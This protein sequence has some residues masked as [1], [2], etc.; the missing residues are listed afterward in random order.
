ML[1]ILFDIQT[2]MKTLDG[3]N[4]KIHK[5]PRRYLEGWDFHDVA[6]GADPIW[7][8]QTSLNEWGW[9]WV[10][11]VRHINA[12]VLFGNG[13]GDII[14][15]GRPPGRPTTSAAEGSTEAATVDQQ[16]EEEHLDPEEASS[17]LHTPSQSASPKPDTEPPMEFTLCP[18]CATLPKKKTLLATTT[19]VLNGIIENTSQEKTRPHQVQLY[20]NGYWHKPA[21]LFEAC[22][23]PGEAAAVRPRA[24]PIAQ[25]PFLQLMRPEIAF[26]CPWRGHIRTQPQVPSEVVGEARGVTCA[27]LGQY[28]TKLSPAP[29]AYPDY[30]D[31]GLPYLPGYSNAVG[32]IVT[33]ILIL[34]LPE[35]GIVRIGRFRA[36]ADRPVP[37]RL[38]QPKRT[39]DFISAEATART[40]DR[41]DGSIG[42]IGSIGRSIGSRTTLSPSPGPTYYYGA[43]RLSTTKRS[44]LRTVFDGSLVQ[45]RSGQAVTVVMTHDTQ[46][47]Q[48]VATAIRGFFKPLAYALILL[49]A[50]GYPSVFCGDLYGIKGDD[51]ASDPPPPA[52]DYWDDANC[53]GFVRRGTAH[54]PAGLV[55]VMSNAGSGQIKMNI[56]DIHRGGGMERCATVAEDEVIIDDKGFGMFLCVAM[57]VSIWVRKDAAGRERFG[58]L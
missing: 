19:A 21:L 49:R 23:C 41:T 10:D 13:F 53:I 58:K 5:S 25:P 36:S 27:I 40:T 31:V 39:T 34:L 32:N 45:A 8:R 11:L 28:A 48:T 6:T 42:S 35:M 14:Q 54:H 37:Y 2:D 55:C 30:L 29:N 47:G 20:P 17:N 12:I 33:D 26:A 46:P 9:G 16:T 7:P 43:S 1:G 57:S 22:Q 51:R 4:F 24:S 44:D 38:T 52:D 3:I 15:P 56:G 50:Q 18:Q